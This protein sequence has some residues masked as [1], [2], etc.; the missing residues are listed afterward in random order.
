M[1]KDTLF[2]N[3][4]G[5]AGGAVQYITDTLPDVSLPASNN[6]SL[7]DTASTNPLGFNFG[8]SDTPEL[9]V[10]TLFIKALTLISDRSKW[11]NNKPTYI[12]T[13]NENMPAIVGYTFGNNFKSAGD[14]IGITGVVRRVAWLAS[15][16]MV[17]GSTAQNVVDGVNTTVTTFVVEAGDSDANGQQ[18]YSAYLHASAD[19][20]NDLHDIR[21]TALQASNTTVIIGAIVYFD[22]TNIIQ[23]PGTTYVNKSKITT[24][25]GATLPLPSFGSSLG[26]KSVIYKTGSSGYATSS[27]SAT[28][29]ISLATGA[30]TSPT[31]L[32]VSAGTG[33]SF[34]PGYGFVVAS[35]SSNYVG[36]VVSISTDT[37]TVAPVLPYN[38]SS[39]T[40]YRS[41][42]ASASAAINASLMQMAYQIDFTKNAY[43][44]PGATLPL[45]EPGG[46]Y[47][48]WG[49]AFGSTFADS[50]QAAAFASG[51]IGF[52]QVEGQFG[53]AEM[54]F[55]GNGILHA[56]FSVNGIP[57]HSVNTGQTG[58]IRRTIFAEAGPGW[59]S[60]VMQPGVSLGALGIARINLYQRRSNIGISFGQLGEFETQQAYADRGT[61]N[62]TLMSLGLHRRIFADQMALG[63][64]FVRGFSAASI[65]GVHYSG[66]NT[67]CVATV[68][69]YGKNFAMLGTVAGGTLALDGGGIG[70]TFNIMQSVATEGF[71]TVSYT[72]GAGTTSIIQ[73][74]DYVRSKGEIKNL[75]NLGPVVPSG[76]RGPTIQKFTGGT[77]IYVGPLGAKPVYI[78]VRMVGA[79]GGGGAGG[80]SATGNSGTAGGNTTFGTNLL[81]ASGGALGNRTNSA[82][83]AAN[84]AAGGTGVINYGV[85]GSTWQGGSGGGGGNGGSVSSVFPFGGPG[86]N[87]IFGGG[88]VPSMAAQQVGVPGVANTGSGGGG[89]GANAASGAGRFGGFGGGAGGAIDAIIF[90]PNST[91]P[92]SVGAAGTGGTTV[93]ADGAAGAIGGSGYIEVTE[94]YQ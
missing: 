17:V 86:G 10:K 39:S 60:F 38:I 79:G 48:L 81:I 20:T 16:G 11:V 64:S 7:T 68:S 67:G 53:A 85:V 71:H 35:G 31:L 23:R 77:G 49:Q 9:G 55:V 15:N 62:S 70:L 26:G 21:L 50:V 33:A 74:F 88:G 59:N 91:Y 3:D 45:L 54:E 46:G 73:A 12:I 13:W 22:A 34:L 36:T 37:L 28:S 63:G 78:R 41:W 94:Y 52:M 80:P 87:S 66:T 75:Q 82:N 2:T 61:L 47:A 5:A 72:S 6:T 43:S 14:G 4:S 58:I 25:V 69:Y 76:P 1:S 8:N 42:Y 51:G 84:Y 18:K 92:Y 57:A 65:G 93:D 32:N 19:E 44:A 83:T 27:L 89:G 24:A 40:I 29:I 30:T 56:T 90:N